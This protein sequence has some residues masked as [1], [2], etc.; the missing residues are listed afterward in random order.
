MRYL[1][2]TLDAALAEHVCASISPFRHIER[3]IKRPMPL[4]P[5]PRLYLH[6][7]DSRTVLDDIVRLPL[8][9]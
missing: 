7:Q 1:P 4:P 6:G 2:H 3:V 9:L 8:A 5:I